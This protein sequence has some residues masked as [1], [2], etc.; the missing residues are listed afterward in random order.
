MTRTTEAIRAAEARV[1]TAGA[2]R[3]RAAAHLC[4][5]EGQARSPQPAAVTKSSAHEMSLIATAS[6]PYA[7]VAPA[8]R[9]AHV[10]RP[11]FRSVARLFSRVGQGS[12]AAASGQAS[13]SQQVDVKCLLAAYKRVAHSTT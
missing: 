2:R 3:T 13:R 6:P 8:S 9:R 7:E 4:T 11:I 12:R 10:F 1:H 5:F